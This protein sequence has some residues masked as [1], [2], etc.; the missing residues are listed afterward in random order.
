MKNYQTSEQQRYSVLK[1]YNQKQE[2]SKNVSSSNKY[3]KDY[4]KKEDEF[5]L[6]DNGMTILQKAAK[7]KRSFAAVA[8]RR[9]RLLAK[10]MGDNTETWRS[11]FKV[12]R[13]RPSQRRPKIIIKN[14]IRCKKCGDII[15]SKSVHDFET[16]SCGACSVDGG[17]EYLRRLGN[18]DD[19]E[20]MSEYKQV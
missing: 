13:K 18:P 11:N 12:P 4:T 7:L 16:C 17:H 1:R 5:I 2:E 20:D 3:Y 8:G 14:R 19:W 10:E 6:A 15:E 9:Q